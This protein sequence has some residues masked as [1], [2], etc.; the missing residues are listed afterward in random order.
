M[1]EEIEKG[2]FVRLARAVWERRKRL[3]ILVFAGSFITILCMVAFLPDL[4]R[5]TATVLIERDQA[6]ETLVPGAVSGEVQSRL[7][8]INQQVLSRA[9]LKDLID[10]FHLYPELKGRVP[11]E[12]VIDQLRKD[13]HLGLKSVQE[14]GGRRATIAFNLSYRG[15]DPQTVSTVTNTLASFFV[16]QNW[17]TRG[18]QATETAEFF[19]VQLNEMKKRLEDQER[20]VAHAKTRIAGVATAE[21]QD[22]MNF[23]RLHIQLRANME[24]LSRLMDRREGLAAKLRDAVPYGTLPAAAAAAPRM[25]ELAKLKAELRDLR[26]RYTE[27]Y[28]DVIRLR[29]EIAALERAATEEPAPEK[30]RAPA[31]DPGIAQ[32][33]AQIKKEM[34]GLDE[35]I[36]NLRAEDQRLQRSINSFRVTAES[37]SEDALQLVRDYETTKDLYAALLKRYSDAQYAENWERSQR[38]ESFR[39]L[40][41]AVPPH[42]PV[43]PQRFLLALLG[44]G[45][46]LALAAC[47]VFVAEQMDS[48][49]HSVDELRGFTKVPVLVSIPQ[50][51]SNVDLA[52]QRSRFRLG[53]ISALVCMVILVGAAFYF[54]HENESLVRL[55]ERGGR[56]QQQV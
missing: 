19:K 16:E 48:S 46:S 42:Q 15:R 20:R 33:N 23:E 43:A 45:L 5:A 25:E 18:R 35:E 27:S 36:R 54:A 7:E 32:A 1:S 56:V 40:D 28:P 6:P 24:R 38:G 4:Y 2:S 11:D 30:P 10:L 26:G 17:K 39:I 50:V 37:P 47:A 55:L 41:S 21:R 22:A 8:T 31:P 9:R 52:L 29:N 51:L 53:M 44:L 13:I 34:A 49:F 3:G 14:D 12:E